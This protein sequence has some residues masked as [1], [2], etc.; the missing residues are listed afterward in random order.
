MGIIRN[1]YNGIQNLIYYVV[2]ALLGAAGSVLLYES[3]TQFE[4]GSAGF[5]LTMILAS[6]V[7]LGFPLLVIREKL[8]D[9]KL[10]RWLSMH[11]EELG[12]GVK[13][14]DGMI[15]SFETEFVCYEANLSLVFISTDIRSGFYLRGSNHLLPKTLYTLFTIVFG[16]WFLDLGVI[17]DNFAKIGKNLRDSNLITVDELFAKKNGATEPE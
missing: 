3:V 13:G 11:V 9:R 7:V 15:Y 1:T 2:L 17:L 6:L 16:W 5:S 14:P 8:R 12:E 10:L 4:V